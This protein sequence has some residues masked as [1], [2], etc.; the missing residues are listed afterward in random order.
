MQWQSKQPLKEYLKGIQ[1]TLDY[2]SDNAVIYAE[3]PLE[4]TGNFIQFHRR[5][6]D[7]FI[8][9]IVGP[10][11]TTEEVFTDCRYWVT[12]QKCSLMQ[13]DDAETQ[14]ALANEDFQG[15]HVTATNLS[16]MTFAKQSH[17]VKAD[18]Q[19]VVFV[20]E[21]A[22]NPQS[23]RYVFYSY[24]PE[25][26][27]G[28]IPQG[29]GLLFDQWFIY[30]DTINDDSDTCYIEELDA[31]DDYIPTDYRGRPIWISL[32]GYTQNASGGLPEEDANL[33][34]WSMNGE[35]QFPSGADWEPEDDL[36]LTSLSLSYRGSQTVT[37]S[38]FMESGTGRLYCQ[39]CDP[40]DLDNWG[41]TST[42]DEK[43]LNIRVTIRGGDYIY[44]GEQRCWTPNPCGLC[45]APSNDISVTTNAAG[46][47]C[48][49][50]GTYTFYSFEDQG[51]CCVWVY[52]NG[53]YDIVVTKARGSDYLQQITIA[54]TST[55]SAAA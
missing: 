41:I 49:A 48:Q 20:I 5:I 9:Q 34:Q 24:V 45:T 30:N 40:N 16:E 44:E 43:P 55:L 52:T 54:L 50:D 12:E 10:A 6:N 19:V 32:A 27:V 33:V 51:A 3:A 1:V 46:S 28:G 11:D 31:N 14:V 42:P 25:K 13:S 15:R 21:D 18:S 36:L 23:D 2:L 35:A 47:P 26:V 22:G 37:Y 38:V 4:K 39:I 7:W 29:N 53:T 8:G 17:K